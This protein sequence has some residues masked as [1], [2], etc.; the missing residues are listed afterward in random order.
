MREKTRASRAETGGA[1][2]DA[3]EALIE[4]GGV[5]A[6]GAREVAR[7]VGVAV[8][9]VYL[10]HGSLDAAITAANGR[11]LARIDA[12]MAEA[13]EQAT[14]AGGDAQACCVA[15]GR[16]YVRFARTNRQAWAALFEFAPQDRGLASVHHAVLA[17]MVARIVEQLERLDPTAPPEDLPV[18]ARTFFGAVHGVVHTALEGWFFGTPADRLEAEVEVLVRTLVAGVRG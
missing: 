8:G 10:V 4:E 7:R 15:L 3:I 6:V 9:S 1:V 5:R 11:T 14:A 17:G 12:A 16:C 2:L 18:R 13:V